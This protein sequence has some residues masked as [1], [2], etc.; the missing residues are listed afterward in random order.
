M[1][2]RSSLTAAL[3]LLGTATPG[4]AS[5]QVS[6]G[7]ES[8]YVPYGFDNN[9]NVVL[10]LE[11]S[12]PDS[13]H[14]LAQ[15]SVAKDEDQKTVTIQVNAWREQRPQCAPGPFPFQSEVELGTM[16]EG[17]WKIVVRDT[18]VEEL[19][20]VSRASTTGQDDHLYAPVEAVEIVR[21]DA[22]TLVARLTGLITADCVAYKETQVLNQGKVL[23]LLPIM[24]VR[25]TDCNPANILLSENVEL[26]GDQLPGHYLLHV[27]SLN[28][29]ALNHFYDVTATR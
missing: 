14:Q 4:L 6:V 3:L 21:N 11:G 23:V 22:G 15:I 10:M 29:K 16:N 18:T 9:D 8:L 7:A 24:E 5:D 19:L 20:T 12:L 17:S 13:C 28:G 1:I 2:G 27:R 25:S 26:P